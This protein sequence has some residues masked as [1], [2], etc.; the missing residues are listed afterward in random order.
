[1]SDILA[2]FARKR[3]F[4]RILALILVSEIDKIGKKRTVRDLI[5]IPD[6]VHFRCLHCSRIVAVVNTFSVEID[7][8]MSAIIDPETG[9]LTHYFECPSC[10]N[11]SRMFEMVDNWYKENSK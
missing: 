3:P 11:A 2:I 9:H 7:A 4:L 1:M 8:K 10:R 5:G 6:D